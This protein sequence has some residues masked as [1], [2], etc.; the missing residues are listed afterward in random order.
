MASLDNAFELL[1]KNNILFIKIDPNNIAFIG[2]DFT[3]PTLDFKIKLSNTLDIPFDTCTNLCITNVIFMISDTLTSIDFDNVD[4]MAN[5][6]CVELFFNLTQE[7]IECIKNFYTETSNLSVSVTVNNVETLFDYTYF[8]NEPYINTETL[9]DTITYVVGNCEY[10]ILI[11]NGILY[12]KY[13]VDNNYQLMDNGCLFELIIG[14]VIDGENVFFNCSDNDF[15]FLYEVKEKVVGCNLVLTLCITEPI[16]TLPNDEVYCIQL[17]NKINDIQI[18]CI[19]DFY[20]DDFSCEVSDKVFACAQENC[21]V[22]IVP[23][24]IFCNEEYNGGITYAILKNADYQLII[25][26]GELI[27]KINTDILINDYID[28]QLVIGQFNLDNYLFN[29]CI[30]DEWCT[31]YEIK[32]ENNM[33]KLI[34]PNQ[35]LVNGEFQCF[36]LFTKLTKKQMECIKKFYVEDNPIFCICSLKI[37]FPDEIIVLSQQDQDILGEEN[38]D[39]FGFSISLNSDGDRIV[40]GAPFNDDVDSSSGSAYVYEYNGTNWQQLGN[41]INGNINLLTGDQLGYSVSMNA[42]GDRY[43][44]GVIGHDDSR[45]TVRIYE[46]DGINWV[47]L[48]NQ[49]DG[50]LIT[51]YLSFGNSVG[52]NDVGDRVVI[53]GFDEVGINDYTEKI[54]IYEFDGINWVKLGNTITGESN[55]LIALNISVSINAIGDTIIY[56]S[57]TS[58]KVKIYKY[59]GVSWLQLGGDL[60]GNVAFD[61]FGFSVS[62]NDDG[63]RV[64]IGAPF[65]NGGGVNSGQVKVFQ[66]D[67]GTNIWVQLGLDIVG[68]AA[69]DLSGFSV[70][71]NG[72]GDRII[73]GATDNDGNG[74]NSGQVRI[75]QY[76]GSD[77]I[78]IVQD[79]DG[80]VIG[81]KLG[82][83]V[84]INNSG[85]VVAMS[86]V[87]NNNNTG[88]VKIFSINNIA[89]PNA[90]LCIPITDFCCESFGDINT[91]TKGF[92]DYELLFSKNE[93]IL[94]IDENIDDIKL[95]IKNNND[96]LLTECVPEELLEIGEVN[97]DYICIAEEDYN[98]NEIILFTNLTNKQIECIKIFYSVKCVDCVVDISSNFNLDDTIL[99]IGNENII[100]SQFCSEIFQDVLSFTIGHPPCEYQLNIKDGVFSLQIPNILPNKLKIVI[101]KNYKYFNAFNSQFINKHLPLVG[102]IKTD[103]DIILLCID[104]VNTNCL[105]LFDNLSEP[106]IECIK[107]FYTIGCSTSGF[108]TD[109]PL[110][111]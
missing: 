10:Q 17:T 24:N 60:D 25:E 44:V 83:A 111:I 28:I 108:E 78:K 53:S 110:C 49:I 67:G 90:M 91:F 7:Q 75:Y 9:I 61:A 57:R 93:L 32:C 71:I 72:D 65:N 63:D 85:D 103:G 97:G 66:Y 31:T 40:I 19:Q 4:T 38:E 81:D 42:V 37:T 87:E 94:K 29:C 43:A 23:T 33:I 58:N 47:Q 92:C 2:I 20:S 26:N 88:L 5:P 15:D 34:I 102:S 12:F 54:E 1:I 74:N 101:G 73:I 8:T 62:I 82:Y 64:V 68:E 6:I 100:L 56:G 69:N 35:Q 95:L 11:D 30:S 14:E 99:T 59:N 105:S 84:S 106:E 76:D 98:G 89:N 79:I 18:T 39:F 22:G 109:L 50:E 104:N 55:L 107:C 16:I 77:W 41:K 27:L 51:N 86:S 36:T 96:E 70:S 45:G 21:V 3:D 52:I 80:D 13:P 48:G 46:Y